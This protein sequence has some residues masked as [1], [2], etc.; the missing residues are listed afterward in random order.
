MD[1]LPDL[2]RSL[3]RGPQLLV[4]EDR[5]IPSEDREGWTSTVTTGRPLETLEHKT[6]LA[7]EHLDLSGGGDG[8]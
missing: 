6:T 1:D 7:V 8:W 4:L 3:G 2:L 5:P